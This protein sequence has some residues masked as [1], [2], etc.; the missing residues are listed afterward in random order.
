MEHTIPLPITLPAGINP[1]DGNN[2]WAL[3]L[4]D[5]EVPVRAHL[6]VEV[7]HPPVVPGTTAY[8]EVR[9]TACGM[10]LT[11]HNHPLGWWYVPKGEIPLATAAAIHCGIKAIGKLLPP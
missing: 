1:L 6:V 2:L 7:E 3:D 10:H 9:I 11:E 4:D 5:Q 8:G